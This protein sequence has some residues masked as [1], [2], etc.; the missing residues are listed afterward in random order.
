MIS[1]TAVLEQLK[2][3]MDPELGVNIVDLG[4]IYKVEVRGSKVKIDYTLTFPGCP[5]AAVIEKGIRKSLNSVKE[6]KEVEMNLVWEPAWKR[7]MMSEEVK[8]QFS[9]LK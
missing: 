9:M 6:V 8:L 2:T 1:K 4:L 3:V 5:L 7:E